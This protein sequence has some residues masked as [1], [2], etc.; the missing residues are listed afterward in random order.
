MGMRYQTDVADL[1]AM[2]TCSRAALML[3]GKMARRKATRQSPARERVCGDKNS[4]S[5]EDFADSGEVDEC[6]WTR[7]NCRHH[8]G[9]VVP[10]F[11]EVRRTREEEHDSKGKAGGG[12][13]T[14]EDGN[15]QSA[16]RAKEKQRAKQNEENDHCL[17]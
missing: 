11:I 4:D 7:E 16:E 2:V 6:H 15:A 8:A 3:A 10:E 1:P 13:P 9:Q 17:S 14:V 5:S 12:R